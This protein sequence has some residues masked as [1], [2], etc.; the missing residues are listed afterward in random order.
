MVT[1]D[2]YARILQKENV[3]WRNIVLGSGA[4]IKHT[5]LFICNYG[6]PLEEY[7][8]VSHFVTASFEV[9]ERTYGVYNNS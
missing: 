6:L 2:R 1:L 8:F 4:H 5:I 7:G 3:S 9:I